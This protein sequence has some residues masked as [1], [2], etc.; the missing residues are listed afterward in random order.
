MKKLFIATVMLCASTI[1]LSAQNSKGGISEDMLKE[2]SKGYTGSAEQKAVRNALAVNP[3]S[4]LSVNAENLSMCD[5]YFSHQVKTKGIT[6]QLSS[7]R[8]WL[9]T[10]LNVLRA[11]MIDKYE[12]PEMVFSHNYL[13]FHD[14]LEKSN[15]FL[16]AIIDTRNEAI[17]SRQVEW[18]LKSPIG[19]GG[20]FTGVSN[21][22]MKYGVVPKS[23]MPETYQSNNTDEMRNILKLKLREYA[24]AL[25]A[26]DSEKSAMALK[27]QML[28]EIYRILAECVGVPPT[29]FEWTRY[30]KDGKPV[31]TKT[32]T[33]KSFYQ[34]YIGADL[35]NNYVMVMND[36]SREYYKVYEIDLDRHVYD[37]E[38]WVYV[39]LPIEKIKE[40]AIASIKDNTAM[41]FSCDVRKFWN[42]DKGTLD[43]NNI[44]YASLFRTSFPMTKKERIQ[45]FASGSTHAMTLIAVDLDEQ[46]TPKKWMVENS[47]GEKSGYK[48]NLIMTDEWFNEYM[49]RLVVEKKY[50]PADVMELLKQKPIML[51]A[52]DP[53]FADEE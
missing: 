6:N 3:I 25:R 26:A 37:G 43:L 53:M 31:S 46:G 41:Y 18:L 22:I 14:L 27:T 9:F 30:D 12:L 17:D 23:A 45:T 33:P 24:L 10:G 44:D 11:K 2:I 42:K 29:E 35:E 20:Q 51:P 38:N 21:L 1:G 8:C 34:E 16:Q 32:Y 49:F 28:T 50:V 52:W 13:S 15:L 40:M 5:T 19:D 7:G 39:N 36:P 48:G 4:E 47:W